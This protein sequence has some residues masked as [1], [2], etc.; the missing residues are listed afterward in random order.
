MSAPNK[1]LLSE[2]ARLAAKYKPKDWEELAAW[3][4]DPQRRQTLQTLLHQLAAASGSSHRP[5][6]RKKRKV[7][8]VPKVRDE[9]KK[10][11]KKD[12]D[13]ADLLEDIWLK[14]RRRELLPTL[15]TLRMFAEAM[16][17]KGLRST[18]RDQAVTELME[19]LIKMPSDSLE[20]RMR[21]VAVQDRGLGD[22]Y[23][24]WVQL[25]LGRP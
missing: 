13:R 10:L 3:L 23:G 14:M 15:A 6:P 1:K 16:G 17:A 11:R 21:E 22:E 20:Q 8:G 12:A 9:L 7:S 24:R 25:I 5:A 18:R 2:L 4:D 19:L